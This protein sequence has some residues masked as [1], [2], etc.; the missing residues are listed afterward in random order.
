MTSKP[1][2]G[3]SQCLLG[4]PVR[5]DGQSK[6]NRIVLEVVNKTL[7][8]YPVC[9]EVE[10]GLGVPRP[11]IQLTGNIKNPDLT[12]RTDAALNVTEQMRHY[13]NAKTNELTPLSG[14]I[15][16]SR[17]PSCGLHSTP[18]F[19]DGEC[20]SNT[21]RGIFA[22]TVCNNFPELPVIEETALEIPA[23]LNAFLQAVLDHHC[24]H[25]HR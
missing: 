11:A 6:A 14:F 3:V 15:F 20:I 12:G 21:E 10:A 9:P 16:K 7:D 22:K 2:V 1:L 23:Q 13:C 24:H 17:S 5:Y 4:K 18:F 19:L 8:F 25:H